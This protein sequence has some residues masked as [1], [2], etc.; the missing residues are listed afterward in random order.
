MT[1]RLIFFSGGVESTAMLTL[2]SKEDIVAIVSPLSAQANSGV[3][4][5]SALKILHHFGL[6]PA[7]P[8]LEIPTGT[9]HNVWLSTALAIAWCNCD[10]SITEVWIG[11]NSEDVGPLN[12]DYHDRIHG[13]FSKLLPSVK[14]AAPLIH[15]S[16]AEQWN[17]IPEG[18]RQFVK[19][20]QKPVPCGVC[21]KCM[22]RINANLPL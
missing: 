16:K 14:L 15:L 21:K 4:T 19:S 22:E 10:P 2:A 9:T 7:F 6:T 12:Q 3:N 8:K 5:P 1:K 13:N 18:V 17:L 11:I 20:C